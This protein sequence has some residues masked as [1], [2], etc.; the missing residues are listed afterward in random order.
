MPIYEFKCDKCDLKF[1]VSLKMDKSDSTTCPY[2]K[3]DTSNKLPP[4]GVASKIGEPTHIPKEIDLAVGRSAEE[5]WQDYENRTKMKEE[6]RKKSDTNLISRDSKGNYA[7]LS[8][9][10][11]GSRVTSQEALKVRREMYDTMDTIKKDSK[12]EKF[13]NEE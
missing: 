3:A 13:V 7:P 10:K 1:E 8:V 6:I 4:K 11:D 2:C 9:G 12:T 5:R